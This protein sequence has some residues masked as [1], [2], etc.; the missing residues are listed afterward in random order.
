VHPSDRSRSPCACAATHCRHPGCDCPKEFEGKNCQF[1]AE[2]GNHGP[3][4]A[5]VVSSIF[6]V[7]GVALA[8]LYIKKRRKSVKYDHVQPTSKLPPTLDIIHSLR[9]DKDD[10]FEEGSRAPKPKGISPYTRSTS[11]LVEDNQG[12]TLTRKKF[13]SR[14]NAN[15]GDENPIHIFNDVDLDEDEIRSSRKTYWPNDA[16]ND[17]TNPIHVF[18]DISIRSESI[19]TKA[20]TVSSMGSDDRNCDSTD[21][22]ESQQI[23]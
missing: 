11:V 14:G 5:A 6:A 3:N 7:A 10:E 19:N 9:H 22:E 18:D 20:Y 2:Y 23:V 17:A 8:G 1:P 16:C 13:W 21:S 4:V 12:A 15:R